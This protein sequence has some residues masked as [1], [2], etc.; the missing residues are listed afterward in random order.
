MDTGKP[1]SIE[2]NERNKVTVTAPNVDGSGMVC[3]VFQ[4]SRKPHLKECV[5]VFDHETGMLS[6]FDLEN[7]SSN[8]YI[9]FYNW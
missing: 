9:F 3:S 1:A 5:L 6:R 4:G 8:I 2:F 7:L